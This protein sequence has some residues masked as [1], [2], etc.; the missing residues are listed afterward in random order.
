M[1]S[2]QEGGHSAHETHRRCHSPLT[3]RK[4]NEVEQSPARANG[5]VD[6]R[7]RPRLDCHQVSEQ[8]EGAP[9]QGRLYERDPQSAF[10]QSAWCRTVSN[11]TGPGLAGGVVGMELDVIVQPSV[12]ILGDLNAQ[13]ALRFLLSERSKECAEVSVARRIFIPDDLCGST[14]NNRYSH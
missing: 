14:T 3:D 10:R 6:S 1:D 9:S 12:V 8:T 2:S 11:I 4:Y 5:A 7:K 13:V